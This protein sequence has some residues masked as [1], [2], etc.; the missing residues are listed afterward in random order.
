ML[1]RWQLRSGDLR[2][3][4]ALKKVA[5]LLRND[6]VFLKLHILSGTKRNSLPPVQPE[7]SLPLAQSGI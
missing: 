4:A 3:G 5:K 1:A 7:G 2:C 6:V